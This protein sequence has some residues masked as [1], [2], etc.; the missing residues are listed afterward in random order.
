M[1]FRIVSSH[2]CFGLPRFLL[3]AIVIS[4]V[5]L[6]SE[7]SS[8]LHTCP[9]YASR[10]RRIMSAIPTTRASFLISSL[11]G[12]S[13]Q[14]APVFLPAHPKTIPQRPHFTGTYLLDKSFRHRPG[15]TPIQKYDGCL[16]NQDLQFR[17][18][19]LVT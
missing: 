15:L 1:S 14:L 16:V 10:F 11:L 19:L 5:L 8:L 2:P 6:S 12:C 3:A 13:S 7:S 9:Y 18:D 4:L 17:Q